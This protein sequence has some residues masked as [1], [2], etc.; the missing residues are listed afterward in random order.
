[1]NQQIIAEYLV[2]LGFAPDQ[3]SF[4]K[5]QDVLGRADA[6]V[7]RHTSGILKTLLKTQVGVVGAFTSI[8][9]A[10]VGMVDK[11][12]M[13]DQSYRLFGLRMMM[14]QE[15]ARKLTMITDALGASIEEIMWDPELQRRARLMAA[16]IDRMG[17][18]LGPDFEVKMQR[19]RDFRAE[20]GRIGVAANFLQMQFTK[21]LFDKLGLGDPELMRR[22]HDWVTDLGD[23]LPRIADRLSAF[24]IPILKDTWHMWLDI[25]EAA[26]GF[27]VAFT[28][29]VGLLSGDQSIVGTTASIEKLAKAFEHVVSAAGSTVRA[30]TGAEKMAAT[31]TAGLSALMADESFGQGL[32]MMLTGNVAGGAAVMMSSSHFSEAMK[33]F[34]DPSG[35]SPGSVAVLGGVGGAPV[36]G[37]VGGS[38]GFG[39]AGPIGLAIGAGIGS[40]LGAGVGGGIGY[41]VAK[42]YLD[43]PQSEPPMNKSMLDKIADAIEHHEGY[44][45]GSPAFRNKN[46]GNLKFMGQPGALPGEHGFARFLD[47][48]SGREAEKRQIILEAQR[49]KTLSEMMYKWAPPGDHNDTEAYIRDIVARTGIDPA[50]KLSA[51]KQITV[52]I[53]GDF[54]LPKSDYDPREYAQAIQE[55]IQRHLDSRT[56]WDLAQLQPLNP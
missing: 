24:T 10:I 36:G 41:G 34:T 48:Y 15:S 28:N 4:N 42:K 53:T 56:Q 20:F 47:Y 43:V 27:G 5:L 40:T 11:V 46:P 7:E 31:T 16:D 3:P 8:S 29:V 14:T 6:A 50:A 32:K 1:M 49:G 39:L 25:G 13:A 2:R 35:V 17:A 18:G 23:R 44:Y 21:S 26:K 12:A 19:L 51:A 22:F 9:G 52:N 54:N 55:N 30:I 37:I 33:K 38:I 45:P